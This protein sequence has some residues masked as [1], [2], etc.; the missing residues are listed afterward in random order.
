MIDAVVVG[1]GPNGLA[2]A[3]T[4]ARAGLDVQL[5]ERASAVGGGLRTAEL[6]LP[7]FRHDVCSAVH[8]TALASPFFREFGLTDRVPFIIP[9]VSYAHPLDGGRAGLA[10]RDLERTVDGLGRDGPAWRRLFWPLVDEIERVVDFTG[11]QLLRVPRHPLT[12]FDYGR[13]VLEQ[14][15]PAWEARFRGDVAPAMLTGVAAHTNGRMPSLATAGAGL[16]LGAHAHAAGWGFPVGG[17][18]LIADALADD[19]RAHGGRI[20]VDHDVRSP[21]DVEPARVTLL[22]TSPEFLAAFAGDRLPQR[23]RRRLLGFTRGNG[24]AKVDFALDGPVPWSNPEVALAPTVHLGGTRAEIAD[25]ENTVARGGVPDAPYVLVT[26]PSI[27]DETRAPAG[28]QVLWAYIHVPL[29]SALDATELVTRQVERFAPG[30]RD[31][32]LASAGMTALD[33]AAYNPNNIGGDILGGA[34]TVSQLLRRPTL[35]SRPWETPV[36]GLYLCSASTP[37]GP[38]V[39]GMNGWYA[40]QLALKRF[41]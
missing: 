1:A 5:V 41:A 7:G 17:S 15:S 14:G 40:A 25:A 21:G 13:R 4:L 26:Q 16:L 33:V 28:K 34:V 31:T 12:V 22:D 27:L 30:F 24:V 39:H 36:D 6:T 19:F 11:T 2:A 35:S 3:V 37:P 38:A 10:Y 8:P 32:I 23:Y 18:Q 9:D 20:L 29:N